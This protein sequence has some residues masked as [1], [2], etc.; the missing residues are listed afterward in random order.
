MEINLARQAPAVTGFSR[1]VLKVDTSPSG[2][3]FNGCASPP[4]TLCQRHEE[5]GQGGQWRHSASADHR[6][7]EPILAG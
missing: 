1:F 4:V 5:V 2:G 3:K 7:R 6:R